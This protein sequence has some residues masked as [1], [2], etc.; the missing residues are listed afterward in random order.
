MG[1]EDTYRGGDGPVDT[2]NGNNMRNPLYEAF[3]AAGEEAWAPLSVLTKGDAPLL[4][5]LG[6]G[7]VRIPRRRLVAV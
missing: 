4:E 1:C 2:C 7:R 3:V 5:V 6:D